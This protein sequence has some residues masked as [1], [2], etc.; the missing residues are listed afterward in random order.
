MFNVATIYQPPGVCGYK[1]KDLTD[2]FIDFCEQ[3]PLRDPSTKIT[4]AGDI[5]KLNIH[6]FLSQQSLI[7]MVIT[8]TRRN[9]ILDVF[10]TN[11]PHYW[12]KVQVTKLRSIKI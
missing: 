1:D 9:N 12:K 7:Q 11:V 4:I 5:N 2:Y 8:P 6:E 10:I 3:I